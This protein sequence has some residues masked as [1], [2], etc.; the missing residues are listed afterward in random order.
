[1][2]GGC[3][4]R[5]NRSAVALAALALFLRPSLARVTGFS[6]D[7]E[8]SPGDE[9]VA[10][11]NVMAEYRRLLTGTGLILSADAGTAWSAAP[12][13]LT[14]VNGSTKLLS[15]WLVDLCDEAIVMSYDRNASNLVARVEPYLAHADTV[16]GRSVVAGAAIASPGSP[17]TWWQTASVAEL[18]RVIADADE[19]LRAHPSFGSRPRYAIFFAQTLLNASLAAP[20][21]AL[22]NETKTLWYLSDAWV[23]DNSSR[24]DFFA[25]AREQ[26]VAT[27]YDAPHAGNRPH[28]GASPADQA[29]YVDFLHRADALG[30]DVQFL[31]GLSS[32]EFDLAFI[33][34]VN[35]GL[36]KSRA[37]PA[38]PSPRSSSARR[39]N[40]RSLA[41]ALRHAAYAAALPRLE[42]R[43]LPTLPNVTLGSVEVV[44]DWP[45]QH[46]TCD[47][48]PGCTDPHDPDVSDTPPRVY[49]DAAGVAH[50][51]STDAESRQSLLAPSGSGFAHNCTVHAPSQ[52]DCRPSAFNFQTWIHSPY[53]LPDGLSAFAL[54][55]MEY[56]G[57][58]CAG[59]SSC[60]ES[61]AG[62]CANEAV[63]LWSSN[64]GGFSWAPAGGAGG[65]A[66]NLVAVS[67][68]TYEYS[69]D[70]FNK[71]ELGFGDPTSV[72]FDS[73][74]GTFNV[75]ISASNPPIGVN[76][77]TG[78]QQRGQCLFR[79][80]T[81]LDPASWRAWDGV[82][83]G[84]SFVDPYGGPV[85][86]LSAHV[87]RPVNSQMLHVNLGWSTF[88]GKWISSGFGSYLF[89]NGTRINCCGAFLYSVSDDL[90]NWDTPQLL[91]PNKQEGAF[92][93]WE[94]DA[95]FLDE[96]SMSRGERNWH[97]SIGASTADLYFW[98][99]DLDDG[100][101]SVKRQAV[102]FIASEAASAVPAAVAAPLSIVTTAC[103]RASQYKP[104]AGCTLRALGGTPPYSW[105]V[106]S[107]AAGFKSG[108]PT[109]A[110]GM[111]LAAETGQISSNIVGGQGGYQPIIIVT[112]ALG[113][114]ANTSSIAFL[115]DAD[116]T[117]GNCTFF[118]S[119]SIF[120]TN[121]ASLPVDVSAAAPIPAALLSATLKP[122][123]GS[124]PLPGP[125]GIPF[126]RVPASQPNVSVSTLV[127]QGDVKT[128]PF[129]PYAPVEG[130]ANGGFEGEGG[131]RH[132]I[133]IQ[134]G[135]P[136]RLYEM[137]QGRLSDPE[138][139]SNWTDSSN[140]AWPD[141]SSNRLRGNGYGSSDACG[142]PIAPLLVT[143][144]EAC[145]GSPGCS[146]PGVIRHPIRFTLPHSLPFWVWPARDCAGKGT[147]TW[148]N[149]SAVP[150]ET[151]LP[152]GRDG[153]AS[154]SAS[155]PCGQLFRLKAA[156]ALPA[157]CEAECAVI[158]TALKEF[159]LIL[160][161][162]GSAGGLIGTPDSRWNDDMLSRLHELT[163]ADVEPV[164]V[165]SLV[166]DND[167]GQARGR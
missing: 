94:Y 127:Y 80:A 131:D 156:T 87:C 41:R 152:Q 58:S 6:L 124:N 148:A 107:G 139:T 164:D 51:W 13:Y 138:T 64:D 146:S 155:V 17:S 55:H 43:D 15:D 117:L 18:E 48:S 116:S 40:S 132:T 98:Q 49:V 56:H 76:G 166:V 151:Q 54:V 57:W 143:F 60:T 86:N 31:S 97:S 52:F 29:A 9:S 104:Y 160:A 105:S 67:P 27:V 83:F 113:A 32:F 38:A 85:S 8:P 140:A 90:I 92:E 14:T 36:E 123:F 112:D 145:N 115:V 163:L 95:A 39:S 35:A 11:V 24:A 25:F 28:I 84:A 88:F 89:P 159:G 50:L 30:I 141:L 4:I 72:V 129:P 47:E 81:P 154:C 5:A 7:I 74:S 162:N 79:S 96:T 82:G 45:T 158:F 77:Y 130:T 161:D 137:W 16:P 71:S 69:R 1:M 73:S 99:Q 165:S 150:S 149:G 122:F 108:A 133:V 106:P 114:T 59:N 44:V 109:L 26:N 21:P 100:G 12:T 23:Y 34:S 75:L 66:A 101:R 144:H 126:I 22:I 46:C 147:C 10:F 134:E 61:N 102:S 70:N 119:D 3:S 53:V 78:L 91:R 128:A 33:K 157:G 62:N 63:Q 111:T 153:P 110:E 135:S 136:C 120:H 42:A 2:H 68:Y 103:P 65:S 19:A 142:L 121:I 37:A 93:D 167:S 118:P 20:A 125:N